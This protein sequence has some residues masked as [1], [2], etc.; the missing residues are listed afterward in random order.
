M[1]K[2]NSKIRLV[3]R[4]MSRLERFL[5][6]SHFNPI[7]VFKLNASEMN[8]KQLTR[9]FRDL[10][11]L[12]H[13][14]KNG[15]NQRFVLVFQFVE[16]CRELLQDEISREICVE[17]FGNDRE[18]FKQLKQLQDEKEYN[19]KKQQ[20]QQQ[21][22]QSSSNSNQIGAFSQNSQSL[23]TF[24]NQTVSTNV[25][26]LLKL[27]LSDQIQPLINVRSSTHNKN[28]RKHTK[29]KHQKGIRQRK[30]QE[31]A[32][33]RR[34]KKDKFTFC[35]ITKIKNENNNND[36]DDDNDDDENSETFKLF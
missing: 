13:P 2:D 22:Q 21:Q 32:A 5:R 25:L 8:E 11:L 35:K 20:Q 16:R 34:I 10:A 30:I 26:N 3:E 28:V 23:Q 24:S 6:L 9:A 18:T 12:I 1:Q 14:D 15:Q 27:G 29:D 36:N 4:E 7:D 33:Q 17:T 19:R 31:R